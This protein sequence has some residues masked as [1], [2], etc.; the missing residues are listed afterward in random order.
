MP[1]NL[2]QVFELG[3]GFAGG[4]AYGFFFLPYA[5]IS[6]DILLNIFRIKPSFYN[7]HFGGRTPE[8]ISGKFAS[9]IIG[10]SVLLATIIMPVFAFIETMKGNYSS[11]GFFPGMAVATV[12]L[13]VMFVR[14]RN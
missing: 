3:L 12:T 2:W 10:L 6:I 5:W 14:N 11:L 7:I 9:L 1:F 4:L 13:L 8:G